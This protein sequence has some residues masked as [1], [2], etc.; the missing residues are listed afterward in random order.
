MQRAVTLRA[1]DA[2]DL[3]ALHALS[4]AVGWPHREQDC[5]MLLALGHGLAACGPDGAMLGCAMR[6]DWSADCATIGMV[7]V[8]PDQQGKGLGRLLMQALLDAAP[9]RAVMLNAT[10]AGLALYE[11]L[12]FRPIG[13][14]HQ[15]QGTIAKIPSCS[16]KADHPRPSN[17]AELTALDQA[18]FGAPRSALI[19]L[20]HAEAELRATPRGFA[21]RRPFGRGETIGPVVAETEDEAI[22]FVAALLRP[23]FQRIDIPAEAAGLRAWLTQ[24]GLVA[25]DSVTVM[26]RG[27]WPQRH[28]AVRRFALASQ[29]LG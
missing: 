15:H 20:L 23:G 29:A 17:N 8:A 4:T 3:P 21:A 10:L 24:A 6:W 9:A 14:I 16:A 12:G 25:V 19:A 28:G 26:T 22:A 7:L 5:A 1:L 27:D 18:A 2:R 11:K 13:M